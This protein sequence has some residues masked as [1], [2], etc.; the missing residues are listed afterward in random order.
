MESTHNKFS[1]KYQY[2][3]QFLKATVCNIFCFLELILMLVV[4]Q[5]AYCSFKAKEIPTVYC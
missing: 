1:R 5:V 3:L 2:L 4:V